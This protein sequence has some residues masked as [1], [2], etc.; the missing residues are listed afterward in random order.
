M[1]GITTGNSVASAP[2]SM[3]SILAL[4]VASIGCVPTAAAILPLV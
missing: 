1:Y 4:P 2:S 3:A